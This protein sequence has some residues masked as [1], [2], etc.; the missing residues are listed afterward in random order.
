M[1]MSE[2]RCPQCDTP[3]VKVRTMY[4]VQFGETRRLYY[5]SDC[6]CFFSETDGTA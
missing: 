1:L 2:I 6:Q 4:T 3:D 5:C